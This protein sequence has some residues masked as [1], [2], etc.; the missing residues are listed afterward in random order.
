MTN[1]GR[2]APSPGAA[3]L[4]RAQYD[5]EGGQGARRRQLGRQSFLDE[6]LLGAGK[7]GWVAWATGESSEGSIRAAAA[8]G[9]PPGEGEG[10][11]LG[12]RHN[13][14]NAGA[15]I[16]TAQHLGRIAGQAAQSSINKT[17]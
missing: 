8:H 10:K 7:M 1:E 5:E 2:Q 4:R 17:R 15:S 6:L 9:R 3:E 16:L 12:G 14:N 11:R 13:R